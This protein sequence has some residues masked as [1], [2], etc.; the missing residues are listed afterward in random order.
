MTTILV[1][2][3]MPP[4]LPYS[5]NENGRR[6]NSQLDEIDA[7]LLAL[8]QAD[9]RWT[10]TDLAAEVGVSD[11]TVHNRMNRLEEAGVIEGYTADIEPRRAGLQFYYHFTCTTPISERAE[12]AEEVSSHPEVVEVTELMTGQENLHIKLVGETD[13]DITRM[14]RQLDELNL[15]ITDEN[16]IRAEHASKIDLEEFE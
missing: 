12:V 16:L 6:M 9:A 4:V 5:R 11:N 10:A 15:E 3:P 2:I 13:Q 8:L 1:S 14:A 7:Q